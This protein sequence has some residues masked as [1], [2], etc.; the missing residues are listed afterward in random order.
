MIK[1]HLQRIDRH[2]DFPDLVLAPFVVA[3]NLLG[4]LDGCEPVEILSE[5]IPNEVSGCHVV[6]PYVPE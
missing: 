2:M 4:V 6:I 3:N 1:D 5:R